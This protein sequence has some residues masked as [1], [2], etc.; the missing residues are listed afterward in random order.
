MS[1]LVLLEIRD[2]VCSRLNS[3]QLGDVIT[4]TS[5]N[6]GSWK[7]N[8]KL[9]IIVIVNYKVFVCQPIDKFRMYIL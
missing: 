4:E 8:K 2:Q 7:Q 6:P 5:V 9:Q 1:E 3:W